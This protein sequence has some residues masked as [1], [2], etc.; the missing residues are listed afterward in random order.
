[1]K[2]P[3]TDVLDE[4]MNKIIE[5]L[6]KKG[7][8]QGELTHEEV[9]DSFS[10]REL[11]E[12]QIDKIYEVLQKGEFN[13]VEEEENDKAGEEFKASSAAGAR[14]HVN[15]YLKEIGRIDLLSAEE[16]VEL[17]KRVEEGDQVAKRKIIEANLRLVVS[18]AKKYLGRGLS[19]L[20]LIQEGNMGLMRAVEKFDYRKGYKFSTYATWWIRQAITRALADQARTIRIPVHMV[21]KINKIF[22][23]NRQLIQQK[24][25]EPTVEEIAEELNIEEDEVREI[26]R[27]TREPISLET[28]IGEEDE[29]TLGDFI[30]DEEAPG[31]EEFALKQFFQEELENVLSELKFRERRVLELR[32]GLEDGRPRTLEEIGQE[33]NVTRE[34]IRQ[35]EGKAIR[36]LKEPSCT[37]RLKDFME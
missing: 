11:S 35:I 29:S 9:M 3:K 20:D 23:I 26:Q 37:R 8:R 7:S 4:D 33:F 22:R 21:E 36:K 15:L 32:F 1:M 30:E 25:R 2:H 6:Q 5:N 14:D 34:R 12:E 18:I 24:G 17:A 27:L 19:F 31:P 10:D 28:P 13:L 16:E